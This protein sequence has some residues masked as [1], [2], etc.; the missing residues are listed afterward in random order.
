MQKRLA[1]IGTTGWP[2]WQRVDWELVRA[3]MNGLDFDHR[4]L[5]P[6]SRNPCFYAVILP[7]ESDTPAKEGPAFAGALPI[8]QFRFPLPADLVPFFDAR[9]LAIPKVVE[10]AKGNL[11]GD[12]R[13]LWMLGIRV[14]KQQAALLANLTKTLAPHPE[15]AAHADAARKSVEGF[16]KWLEE[17]LPSKKGPSGIGVESYDW[18]MKN[19]QLVPYTWRDEVDLMKREHGRALAQ[20]ALEKTR[21]AAV[22]PLQPSVDAGEWQKRFEASVIEYAK[23]LREKPVMTL[24][25][26]MQANLRAHA[27]FAPEKGRDFFGQVDARDP[28]VMNLHRTH[29]FDQARLKESPHESPFRRGPLLYN[30]WAGRAEGLATAMEEMMTTAGIL[31]ARPRSRELV[32]ILIANRAA[33]GLAGLLMQSGELNVE[34]AVRFAHEGTPYGWLRADGE[35]AWGEQQNYLEQPGYGT[36]YLTGK[37]Q[38]EQLLG[39]RAKQQG[40]RFTLKGFMDELTSVGLIPV[41]LIRWQMT[42][43]DDEVQ[44]LKR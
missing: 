25:P 13:D 29:W 9:L 23:F 8:W 14:Q 5:K 43:N 33:R 35:L 24:T 37:A 3:E 27:E 44:A 6:W 41:S 34:Q 4:V 16:A 15:L 18:W 10:Q 28:L 1:E 40:D 11:T 36:S 32:D 7:E 17:K 38:I 21:N 12:A 31:D 26:A 42:G 30:M 19:V 2:L 20:L 39:E 22:P